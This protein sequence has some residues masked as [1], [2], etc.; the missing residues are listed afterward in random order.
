MSA[1]STAFQNIENDLGR[2]LIIGKSTYTGA[3]LKSIPV[4]YLDAF[5]KETD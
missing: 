5:N 4:R 1:R 2:Q 3:Q